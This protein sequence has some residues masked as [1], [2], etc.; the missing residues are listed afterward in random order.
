MD[1]SENVSNTNTENVGEKVIIGGISNEGVKFRPSDWVERL[2]SIL[3]SFG[4]DQRLKYHKC[5]YP[6]TILGIRSLVIDKRMEKNIPEAYAFIME[7][8]NNNNLQIKLDRRQSENK[9]N[10]Q[11]KRTEKSED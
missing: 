1:K 11:E 6:C 5:A 10:G 7:F 4:E 2:A 3:S 9:F 8:A